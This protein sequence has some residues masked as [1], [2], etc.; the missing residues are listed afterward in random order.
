MRGQP[1]NRTAPRLKGMHL[2]TLHWS[3]GN[4]AGR[5]D[6]ASAVCSRHTYEQSNQALHLLWNRLAKSLTGVSVSEH[7]AIKSEPFRTSKQATVI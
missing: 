6:Q 5:C 3:H 2:C 1:M 4:S 7:N